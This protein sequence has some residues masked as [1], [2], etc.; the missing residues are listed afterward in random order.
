MEILRWL[1]VKQAVDLLESRAIEWQAF[2]EG[3]V[4]E[5]EQVGVSE[6]LYKGDAVARTVVDDGGNAEFRLLEEIRDRDELGVVF[7]FFRPVDADERFVDRGFHTHD[8]AAGG[9]PLDGL[10]SDRDGRVHIEEMPGGGEDRFGRH[11]RGNLG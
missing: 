6:I 9:T 10:Q 3:P 1:R 4:L 7:P 2:V 5:R 11:G 8:R